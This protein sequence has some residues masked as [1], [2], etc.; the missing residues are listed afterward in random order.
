[1]GGTHLPHVL[2]CGAAAMT[3]TGRGSKRIKDA[4]YCNDYF[5]NSPASV[6]N[7][8][9]LHFSG[10]SP[11]PFLHQMHKYIAIYKPFNVLSQ[12][13]SEGDHVTLASLN[14]PKDIY[15]VG[16]LDADSEG[17]LL[18]TDDKKINDLLLNP[19]RKHQRTYFIQ[20]E[21]QITGEA[22][23]RLEKGLSIN[24]KGTVYRTQPANARI[25]GEPQLPERNPPVRFR[26]SIPTSW[27]ELSL[28]EGKNRQ[29]RKMTAATGFPTL[30]LVR[31]RIEDL[32]LSKQEAG[33]I[34]EFSRAD[35]Y[36]K[37]RL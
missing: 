27:I 37:L 33:F 12:F 26:K 6:T 3:R 14:L 30:R 24:D 31:I 16:R 9:F 8:I 21:G 32:E 1:M 18:L 28:T 4:E 20:V 34:E 10:S 7:V 22:I 15:P 5:H 29:V 13:T 11:S 19:A 35:I 25:I 23:A 36:R 2:C 17:L